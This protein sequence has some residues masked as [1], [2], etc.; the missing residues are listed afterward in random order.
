MQFHHFVMLLLP[1]GALSQRVL[2][3]RMPNGSL[4][5]SPN[6]CNQA[7]GIFQGDRGCCTRNRPDGPAVTESRYVLGCNQNGGHGEVIKTS[8]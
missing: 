1:A 8:C 6:I 2:G 4:N 7:G 3:C 5:P